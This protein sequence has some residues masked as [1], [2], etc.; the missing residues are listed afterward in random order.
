MTIS[1][2]DLLDALTRTDFRVFLRRCMNT[3]NPDR[4]FLPNWHIEAIAYQLDCIMRGETNRLIIN[5]PPRYLKSIMVTVALPAFI[6]G[7]DPSRRIITI[8]Y[9]NELSTKHANDF[10]AI[11]ESPWYQRAFP[12]MRILRSSDDKVTTTKKGFR[13]ST[14]VLGALTGFG[15]DL[16]IIDDPQ[17]PLD[18]LSEPKRT[19]LNHWSTNTL[20]SRLDNKRKG[21]II[22]VMQRVHTDDLSGYLTSGS[23]GTWKVLKL[24]AIAEVSE[25]IQVGR[26]RFYLREAGEALHPQLEPVAVLEELREQMGTADFSAQYQQ[27][28]TPPEGNMIKAQWLLYYDEVPPR[29]WRDKVIQSW[30]TASKTGVQ[31]D[32]SAC[33]TWLVKD[34]HY[35]LLDVVRERLDYPQLKAAAISQAV[36]H[37][38][39]VVLIEDVSAG[40][41]LA[42]ELRKSFSFQY[43]VQPVKPENDKFGRLYVNQAKFEAGLVHFRQGAPY[44]PMLQS[45][46]FGFPYSKTDDIVDSISQALSYKHSTYT[47]DHVR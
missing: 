22:V 39:S 34:G 2:L 10:R 23:K 25:K 3:V 27:E 19:A 13:R 33:T 21:A 35:Y 9:S 41:A 30:D 37:K 42:Q 17:K 11:V 38:P 44:L 4:E 18:A 5:L 46:L 26:D 16:I 24:P 6:L 12:K 15:G 45:E 7:H 32:Y 1:Q 43:A 29:T 36:K 20:L 31:N 8:S 14:S 40:T 47:L 28:P